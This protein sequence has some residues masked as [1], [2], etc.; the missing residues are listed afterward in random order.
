MVGTCFFMAPEVLSGRYDERADV[1]SCGAVLYTLLCG[2]PPF[3]ADRD[4]DVY[5]QIAQGGA[6]DM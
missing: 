3:Y 6:L 2:R 4:E 1:W 5:R